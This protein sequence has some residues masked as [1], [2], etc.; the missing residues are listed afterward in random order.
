MQGNTNLIEEKIPDLE[1]GFITASFNDQGLTENIDQTEL[2]VLILNKQKI[3]SIHASYYLL[4]ISKLIDNTA[5]GAIVGAENFMLILYLTK[6]IEAPLRIPHTP[7]FLIPFNAT[8]AALAAGNLVWSNYTRVKTSQLKPWRSDSHSEAYFQTSADLALRKLKNNS[9]I[10]FPRK[11]VE[12]FNQF[13]DGVF[14][15]AFLDIG[16]VLTGYKLHKLAYELITTGIGSS[17]KLFQYLL[18]EILSDKVTV[19][20]PQETIDHQDELALPRLR[21]YKLFRIALAYGLKTLSFVG[22]NSWWSALLVEVIQTCSP[23]INKSVQLSLIIGISL[24]TAAIL[25]TETIFAEVLVQAKIILKKQET[26]YVSAEEQQAIEATGPTAPLLRRETIRNSYFIKKLNGLFGN[27]FEDP[28]FYL[29]FIAV[30]CNSLLGTKG[31]YDFTSTVA[32]GEVDA[33][34]FSVILGG[35]ML[36]NTLYYLMESNRTYRQTK[37]DQKLGRYYEA[38][39]LGYMTEEIEVRENISTGLAFGEISE[40]VERAIAEE[41]EEQHRFTWV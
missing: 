3:R 14:A 20:R 6:I 19:I 12:A 26:E 1:P 39:N 40:T 13:L 28:Y 31:I 5:V 30:I 35:L 17:F 29:G 23:S 34:W 2:S 27:N 15:L 9:L 37:M 33:P 11:L 18:S 41:E 10:F 24:T 36:I 38:T 16:T 7:L 32:E 22:R 4:K 25:A 21:D 8:W